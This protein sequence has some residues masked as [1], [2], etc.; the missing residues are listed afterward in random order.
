MQIELLRRTPRYLLGISGRVSVTVWKAAAQ[1]SDFD[2]IEQL[3][4]LHA[5]LRGPLAGLVLIE[6]IELK[7]PPEL[8]E[9]IMRH[10]ATMQPLVPWGTLVLRCD[11]LAAIALYAVLNAVTLV[12]SGT[13]A[14][15]VC[16]QVDKAIEWLSDKDP[17]L[18]PPSEHTALAEAVE[19]F[20][21]PQA[22]AA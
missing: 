3:M 22:K 11:S 7:T 2:Q 18:V 15:H 20:A 8:R 6:K 1:V 4:T 12:S 5:Q 16:R 9:R 21:C 14:P 17:T 13:S 10:A 19:R